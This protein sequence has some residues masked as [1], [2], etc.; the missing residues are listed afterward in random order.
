MGNENEVFFSHVRVIGLLDYLSYLS[1]LSYWILGTGY[2]ILDEEV[3]EFFFS[4]WKEMESRLR[5]IVVGLYV[6]MGVV[7]KC[8]D[9]DMKKESR[10]AIDTFRSDN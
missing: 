5:C 1:Y 10:Y 9:L 8:V 6:E 4:F 7:C 2:W 3:F